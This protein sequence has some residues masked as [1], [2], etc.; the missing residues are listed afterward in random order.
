MI[1]GRYWHSLLLYVVVGGTG[2]LATV[3]SLQAAAPFGHYILGKRLAEDIRDGKVPAPPELVDALQDP[4]T[5][6]YFCGGA[7]GPDL[8]DTKTHHD[9]KPVTISAGLMK[10]A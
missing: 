4:D 9:D 6:R 5:L 1:R 10:Y 7:V 3:A 8:A 2:L